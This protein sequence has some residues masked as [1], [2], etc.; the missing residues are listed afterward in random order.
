MRQPCCLCG[1]CLSVCLSV[2]VSPFQLLKPM[3]YF[4][5]S[6]Y[7]TFAVGA[8][9]HFNFFNFPQPIGTTCRKR[10]RVKL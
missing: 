5:G 6:C 7:G 3:S 8:R 10:E 9:P 4:C 2:C 1:V